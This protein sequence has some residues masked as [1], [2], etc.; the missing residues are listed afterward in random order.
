MH[1]IIIYLA[2]LV[3]AFVGFQNVLLSL[4]FF[5]Q[6]RMFL[7]E[8]ETVWIAMGLC[9]ECRQ[10]KREENCNKNESN[11]GHQL[12]FPHV[13]LASRLRQENHTDDDESIYGDK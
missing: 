6:S 13:C 9:S 8:Q 2:F 1:F 12:S 11:D 4:E 10:E 5:F 3:S 7:F